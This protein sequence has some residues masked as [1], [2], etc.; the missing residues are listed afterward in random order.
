V[1]RLT[2]ENE[3]RATAPEVLERLDRARRFIDLCYDLPLDL[4]E[5]SSHA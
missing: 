4:N 2:P 5:I 3:F 1:N